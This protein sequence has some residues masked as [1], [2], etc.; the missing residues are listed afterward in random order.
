VSK[1]TGGYQ[2]VSEW[3]KKRPNG[4]QMGFKQ[5]RKQLVAIR[6]FLVIHD[7]TFFFPFG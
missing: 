4:D 6:W 5:K 1:T 3:E 2:M 7:Q